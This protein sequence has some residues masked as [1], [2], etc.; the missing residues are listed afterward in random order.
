M[1]NHPNLALF[2]I[3]KFLSI[4]YAPRT[5]KFVDIDL[6]SQSV[7]VLFYNHK[8]FTACVSTASGRIPR[9]IRYDRLIVLLSAMAD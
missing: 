3:D 7:T 6:R 8:G 1:R 5:S 4:I 9:V 2:T